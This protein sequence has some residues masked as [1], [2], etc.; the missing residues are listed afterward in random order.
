MRYA[1]HVTLKRSPD[2]RLVNLV[3]AL[4]TGLTDAVHDAV[5]EVTGLD[6]AASTALIALLDFLPGGSVRTLSQVV[7]LT[8]SGAVRLVDRLVDVGLVAR[9]RGDDAR[10]RSIMLT[11]AG[12]RLARRARLA[13]EAA[14]TRILDDFPE[15]ERTVLT[16]LCERWISVITRQ[17]LAQR[18]A[19]AT[20]AGGALCRMCDFAACGRA[21]GACPAAAAAAMSG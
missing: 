15:H 14:I 19:H 4:T 6:T 9:E 20:P 12:R 2:A 7:G 18:A 10:A 17:R 3:G 8:H 1:S 13:R 5:T 21:D 16:E 11:P